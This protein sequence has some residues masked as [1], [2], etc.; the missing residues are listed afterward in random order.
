MTRGKKLMCL[1]GVL[2]LLVLATMGV[3][4]QNEQSDVVEETTYV[5][6]VDAEAV[7]SFGWRYDDTAFLFLRG[8]GGWTYPDDE[9]FPVSPTTM[10]ALLSALNGMTAE[11]TMTDVTDLAEYGLDAP[12][13]VIE[14]TADRAYTI[15]IGGESAMGSYCY[16]TLDGET[17]YMV[18]D[19][20]LYDFDLEL[21]SMLRQESIPA[22]NN[23]TA[24]TVER[25]GEELILRRE[26][27]GDGNTVWHGLNGSEEL[28]LD[29]DYVSSFLST[30]TTLYW[31]NTVT[32]NADAKALKSYGLSKPA[33]TVTVEYTETTQ[34]A[35][36]LTDSDGNT[37]M[38]TVTEEKTFVLEIGNESEDGAYVR[39]AGSAMVYEI[40]ES[41]SYEL[42]N[43]TYED[44]QMIEE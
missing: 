18:E 4:Q 7:T 29:S 30:V 11:K 5:F 10:A 37:I 6:S 24:V 38:D 28:L 44:L 41:Y 1:L 13:C 3:R 42:L 16:A 2:V 8:E 39:P 36:D 32:H 14:I 17:V 23:I 40:Y 43:I 35:T 15:S 26:T 22:M 33:A 12:V 27:D 20:I 34:T 31:S 19:D 9:S 25:K 21:Y